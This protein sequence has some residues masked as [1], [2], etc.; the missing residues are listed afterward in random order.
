[1]IGK[2]GDETLKEICLEIQGRYEINFVEIGADRDHVHFLIQSVPTYSPTEIVT[3]VKS[4][5]GRMMFEKRPE[6][7]KMLWGGNF[8][9]SGYY[10]NTVG[11]SGNEEAIQRY[12]KTQGRG[13]E[14]KEIH[15][16]Q[17]FLFDTPGLAPAGFF[18]QVNFL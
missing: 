7:K 11:A 2:E 10:I 13:G 9:T 18:I 17:L 4:I 6:I 1:M 12:V 8:W 16:G 14:Y 15:R 5:T 3:T